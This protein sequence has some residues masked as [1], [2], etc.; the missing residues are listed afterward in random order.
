MSVLRSELE[1]LPPSLPLL[2]PL[3]LLSSWRFSGLYNSV[4]NFCFQFYDVFVFHIIFI[5]SEKL[6]LAWKEMEQAVEL[7]GRVGD[8]P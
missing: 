4:F 3:L 6:L 5:A 1:T 8:P 2:F 7:C